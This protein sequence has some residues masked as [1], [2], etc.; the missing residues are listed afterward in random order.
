MASFP[1]EEIEERKAVIQHRRQAEYLAEL[2]DAVMILN[3]FAIKT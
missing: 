1:P 2:D 3:D